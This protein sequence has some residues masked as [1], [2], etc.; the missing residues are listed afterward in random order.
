MLTLLSGIS[1]IAATLGVF[2]FITRFVLRRCYVYVYLKDGGQKTPV[3]VGYV[4]ADGAIIDIT[5]KMPERGAI[6]QVVVREEKGRVVLF[7]TEAGDEQEREI[8]SVDT[9]GNVFAL[10]DVAAGKVS[11]DGKRYWWELWL[12][13]H[14]EV[15]EDEENA[16][17]KC[18]EPFRLRARRPNELTLLARGGAALLLYYTKV[19]LEDE[20][21][22]NAPHAVWD[23]ALPASFLFALLFLVPRMPAFIEDHEFLFNIL[24]HSVSYVATGLAIYLLLWMLL[25]FIK[26]MCLSFNNEAHYYLMM[27]NR[28]TGIKLW[29]LV[30]G[31]LALIGFVEGLIHQ[32]LTYLPV[33]VASFIGLA[34]AYGFSTSGPWPVR[35]RS[36]GEL[37]PGATERPTPK[38]NI[39]REYSWELDAP[40]KRLL[41][42]TEVRFRTDE[43]DEI[44]G[45]NPF[46]LNWQ[47]A[48]ADSRHVA[49]ELVRAGQ[50]A[51]QANQVAFFLKDTARHNRLTP[52]EE[53]QMTLG[54]VQS[55]NIAYA[56]DG[57]CEEIGCREEYFRL[58]AETLFDKRGDCDCKSILAAALMRSLGYPVLLLLSPK[59]GHAAVAVGGA[60][61]SSD[62]SL[63]FFEYRGKEYYYCETTGE[64]WRIGQ[65]TDSARI[66]KADPS[67]VIDLMLL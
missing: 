2:L 20:T 49:M 48:A 50:N 41:L 38:G 28:Q 4:K 44:R 9:D 18:I 12:R 29:S 66:I 27:L 56:L 22:R 43:I 21:P 5:R 37:P 46:F 23:T 11:P 32:Q 8:G 16:V 3:L 26:V 34:L 59:A 40:F 67:A 10:G 55:P 39:I 35:L 42:S 45:T 62:E 36:R 15:P 7:F 58:P 19:K 14:A 61:Q 1:G 33:Y 54:F 65:E 17:G 60:P 63:F 6:G 31:G 52:F 51:P 64:G 25:H 30:G 24:G 53:L 47:D 57:V 13:R